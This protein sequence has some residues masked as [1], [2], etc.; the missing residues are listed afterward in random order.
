MIIQVIA[1]KIL[2]SWVANKIRYEKW[3][4]LVKGSPN[5]SDNHQGKNPSKEEV[6]W[7]FSTV[8]LWKFWVRKKKKGE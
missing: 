3:V 2:R 8:V 7:Y 5:W 6:K 4:E 1:D